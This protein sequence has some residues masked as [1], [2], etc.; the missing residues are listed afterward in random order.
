MPSPGYFPSKRGLAWIATLGLVAT[1]ACSG[2]LP[3]E[4]PARPATAP[5]PVP[6]LVE[7]S[8]VNKPPVPTPRDNVVD[9][10][11]GRRI[12]DPYRWLEKDR[13]PAVQNW[14]REQNELTQS[15]LARVAERGAVHAELERLLQIGELSLPTV[16]RTKSDKLRYF[17][18][19]REGAEN[20]PVLV[21]Q[22]G[23]DGKPRALIDPNQVSRAGTVSLDW[24]FPSPDG[25]LVAYG[26]SKNGSEQSTLFIRN[27][28][29]GKDLEDT[30]T[31][32][33][34][35]SVCWLPGDKRF[36]YSRFPAPGDVPRSEA[37]YHRKIYEHVLG[38]SAHDDPVVFGEG[39]KMTEFPSCAISPDGHWLVIRTAQGWSRSELFLA[40]TRAKKLDF[41][42]IT[43][44]QHDV[45]DALPLDNAIYVRTNEGAP[46]Y[47]LYRADPRRPDRR[48]WKR[49]VAEHPTDVLR[50]FNVIGGQIL[51]G[52][53]RA[54]VSR[55][56]RF[57]QNGKSLGAVTLPTLGSSDG[58]TG[59]HSGREA[60]FNFESF[61]RP[62]SVYRLDLKTGKQSS[63]RSVGAPI[64]A[65]EFRVTRGEARSKDGTR[66]PYLM[67]S[68]NG[69]DLASGDNPTLLYGY[70]G[71]DVSLEPRFSKT[72]LLWLERGG[73]YVQANLRGGGEFGEAW[74]R[75]GQLSAKQNVFDDFYAVAENLIARKVTNSDKLAIYGRSNGGL[76]VAAA[77]TQRPKLFRAAVAGVPLTDML[78]YD[79]FLI[80]K[81]WVP[82]YGA[83]ENP[84]EFPFLYAY[85]PYHHVKRGTPYPAVLIT[86]A[87]SDTRVAP[88]HARKFA[89]ALQYA[90]SSDRPVLLWTETSA[91]HG[92]GKPISKVAD[93]YTDMYTFLFW[94]L[95][96]F[97]EERPSTGSVLVTTSW[98]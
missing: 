40:D 73:V 5:S 88:M 64:H 18:T 94:Q 6:I 98:K 12:P 3:A 97:H 1:A 96:V 34:Y 39:H 56:E 80:A 9:V 32:T 74:H 37:A 79:R 86:T 44:G 71:F 51:I 29:T 17:Y 25:A 81:L 10:V 27:V 93:E 16:R 13:D 53:L 45:Y 90:T 49:V 89:A 70:G 28:R 65:D 77:V 41:E 63:W 82:E 62:I 19:R 69:L 91:G 66:V 7:Q 26:T 72:N 95:G 59:L 52:Y 15:T 54:G 83:P 85:S 46:R 47:A 92:A 87:S 38:R 75:A 14:V 55:L 8:T 76:L 36:F 23:L 48:H 67:V 42:R 35:A 21:V 30:I 43:H 78:R 31:R 60:F 68:K 61:V 33:R 20:Q 57:D 24:Y 4:A 58:F 84:N 50:S 22:D 11:H 2:R